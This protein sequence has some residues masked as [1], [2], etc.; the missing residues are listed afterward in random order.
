MFVKDKGSAIK[1]FCHSNPGN[2]SITATIAH[3]VSK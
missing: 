2:E 1:E 3:E